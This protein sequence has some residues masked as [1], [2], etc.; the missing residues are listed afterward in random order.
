[1]AADMDCEVLIVGG[2][3]VGL[4]LASELALAGV[5]VEVLERRE[6]PGAE[7]IPA[8]RGINTRTL[9][10]LELRALREPLMAAAADAIRKLAKQL[11]KLRQARGQEAVR[12]AERLT[13]GFGHA[14][15][16]K[17]HFGML[18]FVDRHGEFGSVAIVPVPY[19]ACE[20]IF[21]DRA[22]AHGA[23][24]RRDCSVAD[25]SVSEQ[26]V[27]TMLTDGSAVTSRYLVGADGGRSTVRERAGFSFPGT[28]STMVARGA[29]LVTLDDHTKL[30]PGMTRTETGLLLVDLV[31]GQI[32]A[33]EHDAFPVDRHSPVTA[34]ELEASLRRV[35]QTEVTVTSVAIPFRYTDNA[36]QVSSYRQGRVLLAGD[37]AHVHSPFGGQGLNLGLQDA[38]NLGW[39]LALVV[40]GLAPEQLLDTYT[41][42]RHPEGARVLRNSR[43]QTMLL[44][45]GAAADALRE[46]MAEV[47]ELPEA[48]QHFIEMMN[49]LDI[50]YGNDTR[51][52][53][54]GRFVGD[55]RLDNGQAV[56]DWLHRGRG[57]LLDATRSAQLRESATGWADRVDAVAVGGTALAGL[58]G[59]LVRPDG[60][61]AWTDGPATPAQPS[62]RSAL[63][64]LFGPARRSLSLDHPGSR[65]KPEPATGRGL[66]DHALDG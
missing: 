52:P 17:G 63:H 31:P 23:R 64:Q 8:L 21:G 11:E 46:V 9:Q 40:R 54:T 43:A 5:S 14:G 13:K 47:I 61:A 59:I 29:E 16:F 50:R 15:A 6:R 34:A 33:V 12:A 66:S 1:M 57:V 51:H 3:P 24:L 37:A 32:V 60:Y 65:Q 53:L 4:F 45:S 39:K 30:P 10:T 62:L 28:K 20:Q 56:A 22:I 55:M 42:E 7:G 35:S 48:K 27:Q 49:G 41:A 2:G 18:P 25:I 58:T 19:A 44:R 26:A 38:A 36:R